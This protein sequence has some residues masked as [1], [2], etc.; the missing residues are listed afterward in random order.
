MID[1]EVI[2]GAFAALA[3]EA[4]SSDRI[5]ATLAARARR[6]RQ[7]RLVLRLAGGGAL[8]A[9]T[10]VAAAGA[11]RLTRSSDPGFPVLDGG[12]GGGWLR[13]PLQFRPA[14]LPHRFG[15]SARTVV[16]DGERAPVVSRDWQRSTADGGIGLLVGWHPSLDR[17]RPSGPTTTVD[18]NGV[19]G[20]LVRVDGHQLG[21]YLT[22]Q[23]PGRQQ[24]LVSVLTPDGADAQRDIAVRVARSVRPDP[25]VTW[26][27]PRFGWLPPE[28]ASVPWSLRHGYEGTH[29]RQEALVNG[30]DGQQLIV[31]MGT[32]GA[33]RSEN[34]LPVE[35][36]RIRE[37]SGWRVPEN[38]QLFLTLPDGVEI[39]AQWG[40]ASGDELTRIMEEIDF[41]PWP[42]M[43]WVGGR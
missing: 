30:P 4:P 16:V 13:V 8:A 19:P 15:E 32:A 34:T 24:L 21:T 5:R 25:A 27:G 40:D 29:W 7:R 28:I 10:G 38:G 37:W 6:Y 33:H 36:I 35:P 12:P 1:A 2:R 9:T 18:V 22:W 3:D 39:F 11:W 43:S 42:D 31:S 14:W 20:Q 41:G 17:D 23:P 26:V